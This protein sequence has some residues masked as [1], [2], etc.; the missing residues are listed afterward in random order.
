MSYNYQPLILE[1][2]LIFPMDTHISEKLVF[3]WQ[4]AIS[5][6]TKK[7]HDLKLN[8]ISWPILFPN[9]LWK[10]QEITKKSTRNNLLYGSYCI[11]NR[12]QLV[13]YFLGTLCE[14]IRGTDQFEDFALYI[15][16]LL[17][18]LNVTFGITEPLH[19]KKLLNITTVADFLKRNSSTTAQPLKL[20][21]EQDA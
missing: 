1:K 21:T 11:K 18:Q 20:R 13:W 5:I 7:K 19:P 4:N 9:I 15:C 6:P 17:G 8:S 12:W 10:D 3:L 14:M 2:S 16:Y